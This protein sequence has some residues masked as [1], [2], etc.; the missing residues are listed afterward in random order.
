MAVQLLKSTEGKTVDGT[1]LL[2]TREGR[3]SLQ[4]PS[5]FAESLWGTLLRLHSLGV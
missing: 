5:V 2:D 3:V 1:G 4:S